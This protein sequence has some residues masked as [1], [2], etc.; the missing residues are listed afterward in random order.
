MIDFFTNKLSLP[1]RLDSIVRPATGSHDHID[2]V[3]PSLSYLNNT[4]E[5]C[6]VYNLLIELLAEDRT[7]AQFGYA[8]WGPKVFVSAPKISSIC[9][10]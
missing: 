7:A 4:L 10:D 1:Y 9:S 2:D 5:D 3:V 8:Q 6:S